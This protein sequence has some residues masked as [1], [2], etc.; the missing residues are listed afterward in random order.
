M[1][2]TSNSF[3]KERD[4]W[5]AGMI[6]AL[7][8]NVTDAYVGEDGI[9]YILF[10]V[11]AGQLEQLSLANQILLQECFPQTASFA[12]LRLY[13]EMFNVP[14][15]LGSP[16]T[17]TVR[18]TGSDGVTIPA[19]T[20]VGAPRSFGLDPIAFAT[21]TDITIPA[22]TTP[23]A[24]TAAINVTA[25]NLNGSYEYAVTF[26]NSSGET[27]Q[28]PD[29]VAVT[30]VNQQVDLTAIPIGGPGVTARKI[31]RQ[32]NG[33]GN[34]Q[35]VTTIANNTTTTYTDNITDGSLGANAPTSDTAHYI[36]VGATAVQSSADGNVAAG[37]IS[38]LLNTP[39]GVSA[40][41]NLT[42]F[43]NG[44]DDEGV[45]QYRQRLME[46]IGDPQTGSDSDLKSWAEAVAGVELATVFDNDNVGVAT[47]GHVTV[48]I[49]GP[50]ASV[51]DSTVIAN[52]LAA[53]QAQDVANI[54]V[55]VATFTPKVQNVTTDVTTDTTHTLADVTP[56]VQ[57][58]VADFINAIPVG[59]TLYV[60]GLIDAIYGL[61][62]I[63]DVTVSTPAS[64]QTSLNTEKFQV[65]T[66]TVT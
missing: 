53:L 21:N 4:E 32:K 2:I 8:G 47:N 25:G 55:H 63:I 9:F 38:L 52:V 16:A 19:G 27:L 36:S 58:A 45:E 37:A 35:L 57:D 28:G 14:L 40:V 13:G 15:L 62:G 20:L 42:A 34:Y 41:T 30:P 59:G 51:P 33:L 46:R 11:E 64:N 65:G 54:T 1:P 48:R 22:P 29:S 24:P 6:S 18:F 3:F 26:V 17:G 12:A 7:Q 60:S 50:G 44:A 5:L 49:A 39:P 43:T 10:A 66:V 61:P 56:E 31:Y 23:T